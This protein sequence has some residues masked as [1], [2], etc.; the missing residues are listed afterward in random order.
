M[1][2]HVL[3]AISKCN[4]G[5]FFCF[6]QL[7]VVVRSFQHRNVSAKSMPNVD[8]ERDKSFAASK[9]NAS[10]IRSIVFDT[11]PQVAS[12]SRHCNEQYLESFTIRSDSAFCL[13]FRVFLEAG[14][15]QSFRVCEETFRHWTMTIHAFTSLGTA[16][17]TKTL[18]WK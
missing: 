8:G 2:A 10:S 13:L 12:Q 1:K 3:N 14:I 15:T 4:D 9:L 18:S 16:L 7:D 5:N 11:D 17:C 6:C